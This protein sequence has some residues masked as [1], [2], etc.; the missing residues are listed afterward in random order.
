MQFDNSALNQG[1]SNNDAPFSASLAM[2]FFANHFVENL[3]DGTG[4][5]PPCQTNVRVNMTRLYYELPLIAFWFLR[6]NNFIRFAPSARSGL[7]SGDYTVLV[8]EVNSAAQGNFPGLEYDF[9]EIIKR[10]GSGVTIETVFNRFLG[11]RTRSPENKLNSRLIEWMIQLGYGQADNTKPFFRFSDDGDRRIFEFFPD[12]RRIM[13][14]QTA[15]QK[16]QKGWMSFCAEQ[17]EIYYYLFEDIIRAALDIHIQSKHSHSCYQYA[18][19]DYLARFA[20]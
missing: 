3:S 1:N 10:A 4:L 20:R 18:K 9:W 2:A 8:I 16:I 15:A 5:H 13:M 7:L 11:G 12:C 19:D 6:E 17:P 14:R